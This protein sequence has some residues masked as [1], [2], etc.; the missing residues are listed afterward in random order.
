MEFL[1]CVIY[2]AVVGAAAFRGGQGG[3]CAVYEKSGGDF[4]VIQRGC[5][6]EGG[7]AAAVAGV[8]IAAGCDVPELAG[9]HVRNFSLAQVIALVLLQLVGVALQEVTQTQVTGKANAGDE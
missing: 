3:V 7:L 2:L 8:D 6:H 1:H 9:K 5:H 4:C